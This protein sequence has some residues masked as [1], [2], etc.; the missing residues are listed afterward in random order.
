MQIGLICD[1]YPPDPG[2]LAVSIHRLACGLTQA[3]HSVRVLTLTTQLPAGETSLERQDGVEVWRLGAFKRADDTNSAWFRLVV[4]RHRERAFDQLHGYYLAG[5]GFVTVFCAQYLKLPSIVSA[6]GND[7]D[8]AVFDPAKASQIFYALHQAD[9]VTANAVDLQRKAEALAPERQVR[10]IPNGVDAQHFKP[11][12]RDPDLE[13]DLGLK[14]R[15]V[16]GFVG[17]ARYKKGMRYLLEACAA[18]EHPA[19]TLLLVGG[20]R[21]G[22]DKELFKSFCQ[23]HP[24][25]DIRKTAYLPQQQLPAW[26]SLLDILAL[27]SLYDGL[28]NALLEGM[29]CARAVVGTPV[30]GIADVI[31]H[32]HNGWLVPAQDAQALQ[33]ALRA[34]LDDAALRQRLGAAARQSVLEGYSLEAELAANLALYAQLP[35]LR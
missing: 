16:I 1:K 31:Q 2:G 6:R 22:E 14:D 11:L 17:E 20:V 19:L 28:P 18:L 26:Y 13:R 10:L 25:A 5:A 23:M 32:N 7:L 12:P 29:A 21:S 27:P 4:A 8:R 34:L 33:T 30:G 3:G 24:Q 9:I 15:Q 35:G